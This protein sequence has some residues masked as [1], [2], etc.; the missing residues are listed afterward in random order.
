MRSQYVPRSLLQIPGHIASVE[1]RRIFEISKVW[2]YPEIGG[3][4]RG[5]IVHALAHR[6][7][8]RRFHGFKSKRHA[9]ARGKRRGKRKILFKISP[10][11]LSVF[12]VVHVISGKL[13]QPDSELC[14]HVNCPLQDLHAARPDFPVS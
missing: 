8:E 3:T 11:I 13:N 14:R 4:H 6:V 12:F 10:G 9:G 2:I 5:H 1:N 7:H